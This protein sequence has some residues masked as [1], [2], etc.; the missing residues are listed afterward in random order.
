MFGARG[1]MSALVRPVDS[2]T[3][4]DVGDG[5][6]ICDQILILLEV[7]FEGADGVA[8]LDVCCP[9]SHQESAS[10]PDRTRCV[11]HYSRGTPRA[12]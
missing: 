7:V 12:H 4:D 10:P 1:E 2:V 11:W 9:R 8:D 5:E 3:G 6:L